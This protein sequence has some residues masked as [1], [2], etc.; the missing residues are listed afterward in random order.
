MII[1][2][3]VLSVIMEIKTAPP[4]SITRIDLGDLSQSPRL[5]T[6]G[7]RHIS[8]AHHVFEK[9]L[10]ILIES[11]APTLIDFSK[12]GMRF[13]YT[14][15]RRVAAYGCDLKIVD[16]MHRDP[17]VFID[18][19][20]RNDVN[21]QVTRPGD[22]H[23]MWQQTTKKGLHEVDWLTFVRQNKR[24]GRISLGKAGAGDIMG[25]TGYLA[26]IPPESFTRITQNG[27]LVEIKKSLTVVLEHGTMN[28]ILDEEKGTCF[29]LSVE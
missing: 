12:D 23:C 6:V 18:G 9:G 11:D 13:G 19:T 7:D 20:G 28:V 16:H 21:F 17:G 4:G 5:L 3:Y 22:V 14:I 29:L 8:V 26:A 2:A 24:W 25:M 15:S 1:S 10:G 27:A